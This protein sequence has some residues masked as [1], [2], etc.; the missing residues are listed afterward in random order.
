MA[1]LSFFSV[2]LNDLSGFCGDNLAVKVNSMN[3]NFQF[4]ADFYVVLLISLIWLCVCE[5]Y[6]SVVGF[7]RDCQIIDR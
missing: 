5:I 7:I 6:Y 4:L 1:V 3:E 2:Q